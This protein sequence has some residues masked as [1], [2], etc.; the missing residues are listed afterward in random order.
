MLP[1]VPEL[2]IWQGSLGHVGL[3]SLD[4]LE[5][6]PDA[7][8]IAVARCL[9]LGDPHVPGPMLN[10]ALFAAE[11]LLLV[12]AFSFDITP[13]GPS[14]PPFSL[15]QLWGR[16]IAFTHHAVALQLGGGTLDVIS[17]QPRNA[18]V[19]DSLLILQEAVAPAWS[20]WGLLLATFSAAQSRP[21]QVQVWHGISGHLLFS[22]EPPAQFHCY[23][24]QC[25]SA[26]WD[27]QLKLHL[28]LV[29]RASP[30][31]T[32]R[33]DSDRVE[34]LHWLRLSPVVH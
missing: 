13:Y 14:V 18:R 11:D 6:S 29:E 8:L 1:P 20:Q 33:A 15:P 24:L 23:Q 2:S 30:T 12:Q 5:V 9:S 34:G 28:K 7:S 31:A 4:F 17:T 22:L 26:V 25:M 19:G 3:P 21:L 32:S 27:S 16:P 10:L